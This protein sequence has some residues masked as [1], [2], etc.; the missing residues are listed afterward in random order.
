MTGMRFTP[1]GYGGARR[2]PEQVKREGWREQGLLAVAADDE[3]LTWP[4]RELVRQLGER[5][6]GTRRISQEA[7]R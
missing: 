1:R 6:Y 3:R 4:E 2:D 7:R 5:L